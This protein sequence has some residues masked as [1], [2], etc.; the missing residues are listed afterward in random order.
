MALPFSEKYDVFLSFSG[1]DTRDN[2]TS[3]LHSALTKKKILTFMDKEIRRGD[4]IS[5]SISRAIEECKIS[6]IIFSENFA[7]SKWCLDEVAKIIECR[8]VNRQIVIPVFYGVDPNNVRNQGATFGLAFA[9]HQQFSKLETWRA[10]LREAATI[11]GWVSFL[12][13]PE[14]YLIDEIVKDILK[15]LHEIIPSHDSKG[16]V[17]I[18]SRL[19]Q[20]QSILC[21]ESSNVLILGIWGMGG[22]GKTTLAGAIFDQISSQFE[23]SFFLVNVRE[24]LKRNLLHHLRDEVFSKLLEDENMSKG[25]SMATLTFLK[26]QLR[27]KKILLVLDDIDNSIQLQELL[28]GQH[29]LFGPGSRIII[30]SRDK[31]VLKNGVDTIFKV[32]EL[33]QQEALQ[34]FCLNAFKKCVPPNV[35]IQLSKRV[36][37]YAKGN[38][39]AL[40]V[41][42]CAL[43]DKSKEDWD[44]ALQKLQSVP[45]CEIQNVL[46]VSFDG[47]DSQEKDIFLDIACFFRGEDRKYITKILDGCYSSV[48]F[49]ITSFI[50]KS[51]VHISSNKLE[52]H[53]LIQEMGLSVVLEESNPERRTR[54]W[55]PNDICCV[56]KKNKGNKAIKGIS[57]DL[58]QTKELQLDSDAFVGMDHLRILKFFMSNYSI[59]CKGE[60]KLP[61]R[62]LEYLSDELRYL[63]WYRFPSKSLPLKFCAENLVVLDLPRSNVKQLWTGVQDLTN[64]KNLDLPYSKNLTKIPDLSRA[65]NVES[66]NLEGCKSL[67]EVPSSIQH[68]EKLEFLILRE[69]KNL[70]RLPSKLDSKCLR[71]FDISNCFNVKYCPEF[72]GNVEELHLCRSGIKELPE[73][74]QKQKTLEI[75]WLIGCSN[76]TRFAVHVPLNIRELYLSETAIKEVPS[77]IQ[78]LT[79]LEILEMVSCNKLVGLPSSISK[80][81]S[82]EILTLSGC[83]KLESFPEFVEPMERLACLYLDLC[84]NVKKVTDSIRNLKSLEH[85]HLS[86]TAIQELPSSIENLKCLKELKLDGCK[87]L[88]SLPKNIHKLSQLRSLYLNNCKALQCLVELP[89]S[90][91]V[92]E[93]YDCRLA[94]TLSLSSSNIYSIMNLSSSNCFKLDQNGWSEII[95]DEASIIQL[96]KSKLCGNEDEVRILYPGSEIPEIFKDQKM[97]SSVSM[98]L[99]SNWH[100]SEGI[101]FGIVFGS[102]DPTMDWR[103]S[104]FKCECR[105]KSK[106]AEYAD[107][108]CKWVCLVDDLHLNEEDQGLLWYDPSL[109]A[110]LKAQK[111]EDWLSNYSIGTFEF[112]PQRW[113]IVQ[114]HCKVVKCGVALL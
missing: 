105:L 18:D 65:R 24:Q 77:S 78:Y 6:V 84:E 101:G 31:Q 80:L 27:R 38:P 63:H 11:A 112:Y 54:L 70:K 88:V 96:M 69:C 48:H 109:I 45:N 73:S 108:I 49:T 10:A 53:D 114:K 89:S 7:F 32:E 107:I 26:H 91:R 97:G 76:I 102:K 50:D 104:R 87:K 16:L 2:F 3:H 103:I 35:R 43:F 36:V 106:K 47:L 44:S 85:L 56:L 86:G 29:D 1:Q 51:L 100:E 110:A 68:L 17:G 71:N 40:R 93:A 55:N 15:K 30:T 98:E 58:C 23:S 95:R 67:V 62:G 28:P 41:L 57:L 60:V 75:V 82:L 52:M 61:R 5:F 39:L 59:D 111:M 92:L 64:L 9:Q 13:R 113:R 21:L 94:E 19:K 46:R 14:S 74:I 90:L 4:E 12:H 99:P 33:N 42:G 8:K 79:S 37:S 20:I 66:I 25:R 72:P 81:K 34:L 22:I 83:T